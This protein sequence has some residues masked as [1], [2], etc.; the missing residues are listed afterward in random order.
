MH[1][2]D[3]ALGPLVGDLIAVCI[4]QKSHQLK[5]VVIASLRV[6]EAPSIIT[7]MICD[8]VLH[9]RVVRAVFGCSYREKGAYCVGIGGQ[10]SYGGKLSKS[11]H[12]WL[13]GSGCGFLKIFLIILAALS[14]I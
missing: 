2:Q 11:F 9:L 6:I 10:S 13:G 3:W 5:F 8:S 1:E 4:S 7:G 12:R 14:A